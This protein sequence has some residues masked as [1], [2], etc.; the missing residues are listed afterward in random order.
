MAEAM[1][2]GRVAVLPGGKTTED[3]AIPV[4]AVA[5]IGTGTTGAALVL[6]AL[7]KN[8]GV[9]VQDLDTAAAVRQQAAIRFAVE[10]GGTQAMIGP[11][12]SAN[13]Q[14]SPG[15]SSRANP[16]NASGQASSANANRGGTRLT[17]HQRGLWMN[18]PFQ[19]SLWGVIR[20]WRLSKRN[21]R[22]TSYWLPNRLRAVA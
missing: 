22:S 20:C 9:R 14:G 13:G 2:G 7:V 18:K 4:K 11:P 10:P 15:A 8:D 19:K 21:A 12:V 17:L 5:R 3:G 1:P 16:A 6:D